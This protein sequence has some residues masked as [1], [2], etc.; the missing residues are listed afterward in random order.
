MSS[1]QYAR[2]GFTRLVQTL[3]VLTR[4]ILQGAGRAPESA[5]ILNLVQP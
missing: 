3:T 5:R 4:L 1:V 2:V